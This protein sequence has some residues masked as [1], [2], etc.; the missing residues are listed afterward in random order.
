M[1]DSFFIIFEIQGNFDIIRHDGGEIDLIDF[2]DISNKGSTDSQIKSSLPNNNS[3]SSMCELQ[4]YILTLY[5]PFIFRDRFD[6]LHFY[7][8]L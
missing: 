6:I 5:L 8:Y 2:D 4:Q 7:L 1:H 3:Q